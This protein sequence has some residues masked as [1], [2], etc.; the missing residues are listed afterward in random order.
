MAHCIGFDTAVGVNTTSA[1]I[2]VH[3]I[4]IRLLLSHFMQECLRTV[5]RIFPIFIISLHVH[6]YGCEEEEAQ[7]IH[8]KRYM[9]CSL[10]NSVNN[11]ILILVMSGNF[12]AISLCCFQ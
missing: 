3:T 12:Q 11:N 6:S 9:S 10:G 8:K 2:V 1:H 4:H 7:N 5:S